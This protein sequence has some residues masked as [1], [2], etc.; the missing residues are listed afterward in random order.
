MI[1][2]MARVMDGLASVIESMAS[3]IESLTRVREHKDAGEMRQESEEDGRPGM[4]RPVTAIFGAASCM[5]VTGGYSFPLQS[6][7]AAHRGGFFF[8]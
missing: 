8:S 5:V 7:K 6:R 3:V 4:E 1:D 2:S